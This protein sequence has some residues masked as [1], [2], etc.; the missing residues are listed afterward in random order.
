MEKFS[1]F[2]CQVLIDFHVLRFLFCT[3][4]KSVS[5]HFK[6]EINKLILH[7]VLMA[8]CLS[9]GGKFPFLLLPTRD[10]IFLLSTAQTG[11]GTVHEADLPPASS[12]EVKNNGAAYLVRQTKHYVMKIMKVNWHCALWHEPNRCLA[13]TLQY[14]TK[15]VTICQQ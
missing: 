14:V 6:V 5:N 8:W 7:Y 1:T 10:N 4:Q 9:K 11:C 15:L 12:A 13:D 3:G 2:S